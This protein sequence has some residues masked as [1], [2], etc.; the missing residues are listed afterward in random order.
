[1]KKIRKYGFVGNLKE[2]IFLFEDNDKSRR[3]RTKYF[4]LQNKYTILNKIVKW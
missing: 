4:R 3:S 1:M 2:F